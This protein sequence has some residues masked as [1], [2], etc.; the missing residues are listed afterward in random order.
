[1]LK[2]NSDKAS[3][4]VKRATDL[5]STIPS[6]KQ[7]PE[8]RDPDKFE[9]IYNYPPGP[10]LRGS[11]L[12][13]KA[14]APVVSQSDVRGLYV[15]IPFCPSNCSYCHYTRKTPQSTN[16]IDRY[17]EY[18]LSELKLWLSHTTTDLLSKVSTVYFGG[19]TPTILSLS[20]I[21]QLHDRLSSYLDLGNLV[22]YTWEATP[23][24]ITKDKL[25]ML[26]QCGVNRISLGIQSMN[27]SVLDECS[28]D[29]DVKEA[30]AAYEI[31]RNAG[32]D[33]INI[34]LIYGF[35][36]DIQDIT[37]WESTLDSVLERFLPLPPE[38][39]TTHQLR[40]KP[41]T[42]MYNRLG[43]LPSDCNRMLQ[44]AMAHVAFGNAGYT[45]IEVDIFVK[46][47][48]RHRHNHQQEKWCSFYQ[49]LGIGLAAYGYIGHNHLSYFNHRQQS[50][51]YRSIDNNMLPISNW[52]ELSVID[53]KERMLVMGLTFFEGIS[54]DKWFSEFGEK[55]I[56][57]HP[58]YIRYRNL[59]EKL[60]EQGLIEESESHIRLTLAG[61]F[62][63]REIRTLFYGD[64]YR[65]AYQY[66]DDY[67]IQI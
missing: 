45:A 5:L 66:F 42:P 61:G 35:P 53:R 39:I 10:A 52:Q 57:S 13:N 67:K 44:L 47:P 25:M 59:I 14:D 2:A 7:L 55:E 46:D 31:I 51:Y 19:G 65:T 21:G 49:H 33:N 18:I 63:S 56:M 20:Q 3:E 34:D 29:H 6:D 26:K 32:F 15:H 9:I 41:E 28:R 1:M 4:L 17:L 64:E 54:K 48:I 36:A 22:E 12:K 62:Y 30:L 27:S 40:L 8:A 37:G 58:S 11:Q 16:E 23:S 60:K 24:T 43:Q 38:S 50:A